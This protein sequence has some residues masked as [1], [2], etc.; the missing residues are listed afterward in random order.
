MERLHYPLAVCRERKRLALKM[1]AGNHLMIS[2]E[3]RIQLGPQ[4]V[5]GKTSHAAFEA[6]GTAMITDIVQ[7]VLYAKMVTNR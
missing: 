7:R 1:E 4:K 3:G 2:Y 6:E 5:G